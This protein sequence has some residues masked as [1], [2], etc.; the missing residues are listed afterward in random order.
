MIDSAA[1]EYQTL[2]MAADEANGLYDLL[3]LFDSA[4]PDHLIEERLRAAKQALRD[5]VRRDWVRLWYAS[6]TSPDRESPIDRDAVEAV[7]ENPYWWENHIDRMVW[8]AATTAGLEAFAGPQHEL[9]EALSR[10][11]TAD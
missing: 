9:L 11:P 2:T 4:F 5:L 8:F 10:R 3:W 6:W 1:A 7:A